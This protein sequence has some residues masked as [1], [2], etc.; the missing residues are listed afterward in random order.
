[1]PLQYDYETVQRI[2][3]D[4]RIAGFSS[5]VEI[6]RRKMADGFYSSNSGGY[7]SGGYYQNQQSHQPYSNQGFYNSAGTN[8]TVG[9]YASSSSQPGVFQASSTNASSNSS[10]GTTTNHAQGQQPSQSQK[11]PMSASIFN[12]TTIGAFSAAASGDKDAMFG[13]AEQAGKDFLKGGTSRLIPGLELFMK[14]LRPYFAVNNTFVRKKMQRVVF[15]FLSKEWDRA[16]STSFLFHPSIS[17][18]LLMNLYIL[19]LLIIFL[20]RL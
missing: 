10:S 13:Y 4:I 12:P 17:R 5:E 19:N 15:S 2:L 6:K 9:G 8:A 14:T 1:M 11:N 16:V 3:S 20:L 7:N 18:N